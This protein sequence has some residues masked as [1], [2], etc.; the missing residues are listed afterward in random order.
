MWASCFSSTS[1]LAV[2]LPGDPAILDARARAEATARI[3]AAEATL[4]RSESNSEQANIK[5]ELNTSKYERAK[6]LKEKRVVSDDEFDT[7]KADYLASAQAIKTAKFDTEIARFEWE[8][9]RAAVS[10][11]TNERGESSVEPFEIHAPVAGKILR[12]FQESSTVVTVG[13]PLLEL[14]DPQKLE[15][16]I[17][18]LSTDAVRI[19]PGAELTIEHWGGKSPLQG[20]VRVIE[21]AAFTKVSS[22]GVE[23]QRVNIIADFSE[24]ADGNSTLGDGYRVEARITIDE[25]PHALLIPNSAL[26]RHQREWHVLKIMDDKAALRR[27]AIGL[28]NESHSQVTKGL[29]QG[30]Q[31][32]VYPSDDLSP[33][34]NV[35]L[36]SGGAVVTPPAQPSE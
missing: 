10:Q 31:V 21:P 5:H 4:Q 12:V 2:I 30:D 25:L 8:M 19:K 6:D 1:L 33:C 34:T 36:V 7:T 15:V 29:A 20:N 11:F 35:R 14:G 23:E 22:L 16:E 13:A 18:V 3:Q 27:V 26:F 24:S 28:Q 17:D 9:A 32:I